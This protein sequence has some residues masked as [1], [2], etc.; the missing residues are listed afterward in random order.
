MLIRGVWK[1]STGQRKGK[2][3]NGSNVKTFPRFTRTFPDCSWRQQTNISEH[4]LQNHAVRDSG[5]EARRRLVGGSSER[6]VAADFL[7]RHP[8]VPTTT[9]ERG[10]FRTM[11]PRAVCGRSL[12]SKLRPLTH[13]SFSQPRFPVEARYRIVLE[14]HQCFSRPHDHISR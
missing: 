8:Y 7:L 1:R 13:I 9:Y 5:P 2:L 10:G 14:N 12:P 11:M 4:L 6:Y 3:L